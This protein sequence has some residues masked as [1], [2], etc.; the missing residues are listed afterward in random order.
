M[1]RLIIPKPPTLLSTITSICIIF[2]GSSLFAGDYDLYLKSGHRSPSWDGMVKSGFEAYESKDIESAFTF[3]QKAYNL[4]CRDGILLFKLAV[5]Y[6]SKKAYKDAAAFFKEAKDKLLTQYPDYPETKRINEHLGRVYYQMDQ[7]DM[8]F[9]ELE[10]A[11]KIDPQNF[12]LLFMTAQILRLNKQY[13]AAIE[14]FE[15]ALAVIASQAS[16]APEK[17]GIASTASKNSGLATTAKKAIL[18]ELMM[19]YFEQKDFSKCLEYAKLILSIYPNDQAA[20][21]YKR[22]VE[23]AQYRQKELDTIKKIVQ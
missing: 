22:A 13:T 7:F 8:A 14:R 18:T 12:M 16:Q 6:E 10:E 17:S 19:L 11:L 9:P 20:L 2:M 1:C 5:L 4:G 15:K 21:S 23:Q 3:I